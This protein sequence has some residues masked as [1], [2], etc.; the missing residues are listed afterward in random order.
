MGV[1]MR[2]FKN[3]NLP[4]IVW[5][6]I[7]FVFLSTI[8]CNESPTEQEKIKDPREY[9]WTLDT[10]K[11]ND[12]TIIQSKLSSI[13]GSSEK[14]VY[15]TGHTDGGNAIFHFDGNK[16]KQ[17]DLKSIGINITFRGE[18]IYGFGNNDIWIAG[19]MGQVHTVGHPYYWQS[20]AA[21]IHYNGIKWEQIE[22]PVLNKEFLFIR[23]NNP[24]NLWASGSDGLVAHYDGRTWTTDSIGSSCVKHGAFF[25]SIMEHNNIVYAL[26]WCLPNGYLYARINNE[27]QLIDSVNTYPTSDRSW[28]G[29][30]YRSSDNRLLFYGEKGI[31][32]IN[33]K[34]YQKLTAA[35]TEIGHT[36]SGLV[37][38]TKGKFLVTHFAGKLYHWENGILEE[39][40][41]FSSKGFIYEIWANSKEAFVLINKPGG[42]IFSTTYVYHGK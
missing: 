26:R 12:P 14:D 19:K 4:Y 36:T 40:Q 37:E 17:I 3:F 2:T 32:E 31:W 1:R 10:L 16:W 6:E 8:S 41:D 24:N 28:R 9:T 34:T 33:G 27:W 5:F 30:L 21:L 38:Y 42:G 13:W 20:V 25:L 29:A 39:L 15:V 23:G 11:Y 7:L 35:G 18:W 22:L